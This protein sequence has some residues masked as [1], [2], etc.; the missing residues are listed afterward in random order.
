MRIPRDIVRHRYQEILESSNAYK[1]FKQILIKT[2]NEQNFLKAMEMAEDRAWG[3]PV[4]R[5]ENL[6]LDNENRPSTETLIETIR[7]LRKE[8]EA[9]RAGAQVETG[10]REDIVLQ[11]ERADSEDHKVI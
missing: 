6:S 11:S 5:N 3:K 2:Q 7:V 4:Q 1:R 10:K 9:F 8:L